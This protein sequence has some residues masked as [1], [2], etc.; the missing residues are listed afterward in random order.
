VVGALSA[1]QA[2]QRALAGSGLQLAVTTSGTLTVVPG[3]PPAPVSSS[4]DSATLKEVT[5]KAAP[6]LNG[7]TEGSTSYTATGPSRMATGLS[8]TQRETP[9]AVTVVTQQQILD[10]NM[11]SL[12]D[13]ANAATGISYSKNGTERSVTTRGLQVSDLQIDGMS[14]SMSENY[15]M[16]AMSG[17]N[18]VIYDRVESCAV[19][20]V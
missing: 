1:E 12:D 9:Q 19:P 20:T 6:E 18:L 3:N 2:A 11:Q 8:L 7:V 14:V 16:D 17:N 4:G 13:V 5:V 10:Q 15:S